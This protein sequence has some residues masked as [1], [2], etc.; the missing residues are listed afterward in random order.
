MYIRMYVHLHM[1]VLA[2]ARRRSVAV[3]VS[4]FETEDREFDSRQGVRF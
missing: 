2:L 4:T 1:L 3:N